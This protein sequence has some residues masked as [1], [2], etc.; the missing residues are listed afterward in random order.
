MK[1]RRKERRTPTPDQCLM[2]GPR[3]KT[4]TLKRTRRRNPRRQTKKRMLSISTRDEAERHHVLAYPYAS[5]REEDQLEF[6]IHLVDRIR[7][8][9][10]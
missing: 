9:H 5:L 7:A 8:A 6:G 1:Q 2:T 4:H 10:G 3:Q